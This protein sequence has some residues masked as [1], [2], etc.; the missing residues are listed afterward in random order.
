MDASTVVG[1]SLSSAMPG[2]PVVEGV[3]ADHLRAAVVSSDSQVPMGLPVVKNAMDSYGHTGISHLLVALVIFLFASGLHYLIVSRLKLTNGAWLMGF[4]SALPFYVSR[5]IRDRQKLGVGWLRGLLKTS[6]IILAI[7]PIALT[8]VL[9]DGSLERELPMSVHSGDG[10]TDFITSVF[11]FPV[12]AVVFV[13]VESMRR[14][15][16]ASLMVLVG[17]GFVGLSK[18][19]YMASRWV[20]AAGYVVCFAGVGCAAFL[21]SEGVATCAPSRD[22]A[23]TARVLPA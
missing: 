12:I 22:S 9:F 10:L 13:V 2:V 5:E 19:H 4:C 11:L 15:A 16:I 8:T 21:A 18:H 7:A 17:A 23:L 20:V 14:W 6:L 1:I 3:N